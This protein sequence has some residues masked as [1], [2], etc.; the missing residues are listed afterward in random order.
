[1]FSKI[2]TLARLAVLLDSPIK[3]LQ[4]SKKVSTSTNVI[5]IN[6]FYYATKTVK[7]LKKTVFIIFFL[8]LS[9]ISIYAQT[10][11]FVGLD[12]LVVKQIYVSGDTIWAGTAHR[13]GN[14]DKSGLYFSTDAG[15]NWVQIDSAL[16]DGVILGFDLVPPL[17]LFIL[18]GSGAYSVAG[19][20]YKSTNNGETWD[21]VS[22]NINSSIQWFG[23]S[24]F[25][26]NEVYALT[27]NPFPAGLIN[28]LYKSTDGGN[29]WI[30]NSAFPGSSHGSALTFA[31]DMI[32]ST[33]LFVTVDTVFDLHLYKST[34]KGFSWFRISTPLASPVETRT[35]LFLPGRL[36]LFA[37]YKASDNDEFNWYDFD[38]GLP[39][40]QNYLSFY[41]NANHPNKL[42]NLRRDGLYVAKND[43]IYWQLIEGTDELPLNIGSAGFR[44]A[45]VGQM[46]NLFINQV[47]DIIYIGTAQGIYKSSLLTNV[48]DKVEKIIENFSLSQNY[49]NP[50]NPSTVISYSLAQDADVT[51]KVYDMLG[52]EVLELLNETQPVGIYEINFNGENLASGVYIYRVIAR[53]NGSVL[54]TDTKRMILIK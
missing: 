9:T 39:N 48:K 42:F 41:M 36:Y 27:Y 15:N 21:N 34:N 8:L 54:F 44:F 45:D 30:N 25:N 49:P 12:S 2:I 22:S 19:T 4:Y 47:N 3:L 6:I 1:M 40:H 26:K 24:P 7:K 20:L 18:K 16:G 46:T 37:E 10:W 33:S 50:F 11:E 28:I 32:D 52:T 35:D 23:I 29:T 51:L 43:T 17:T 38:S 5:N 53:K 14:L 31:F 13:V